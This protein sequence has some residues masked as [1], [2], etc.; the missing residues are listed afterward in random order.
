MRKIYVFFKNID[1][2]FIRNLAPSDHVL[3]NQD[4]SC[5]LERAALFSPSD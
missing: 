1:G 2:S 4:G 5:A 3:E